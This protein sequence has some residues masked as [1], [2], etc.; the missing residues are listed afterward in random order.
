MNMNSIFHY[1]EHAAIKK[2]GQ[3]MLTVNGVKQNIG[4][5]IGLKQA[6]RARSDYEKQIGKKVEIVRIK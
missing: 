5:F 3:Y 2:H 1:Q 6:E 4:K